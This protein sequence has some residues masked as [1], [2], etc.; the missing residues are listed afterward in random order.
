MTGDNGKHG[1]NKAQRQ[2]S[3][4]MT[5]RDQLSQ[6]TGRPAAPAPA[7]PPRGKHQ[8]P[9]KSKGQTGHGHGRPSVTDVKPRSNYRFVPL[10]NQVHQPA[11][12]AQVSHDLPFRDG[13]CGS[14]R[15]RIDAHTP[16]F[17]GAGRAQAAKGNNELTPFRTAD[18]K[19]G[20]P[21]SSLRGML[22]NV[23]GIATFG[24]MGYIDD[25]RLGVRD[26]QNRNLYLEKMNNIQT[27]WMHYCGKD[28]QW[29]IRPVTAHRVKH[30]DLAGLPAFRKLKLCEKQTGI[31]RLKA[32][33]REN[34]RTHFDL[35]GKNGDPTKIIAKPDPKGSRAGY[36]V[37]TGQPGG[38]KKREFL[39]ELPNGDR[40]IPVDAAVYR[41]FLAIRTE[42]S[43]QEWED[44]RQFW[45]ELG[46]PVFYQ[47]TGGRVTSFGLAQ[48][49]KLPYRKT[50][51]EALA[52]TSQDHLDPSVRDFAELMFGYVQDTAALKG[53]VSFGDARLLGD[54]QLDEPV[55]AVL[56]QPRPS[57]YPYY[58]RQDK[59][60]GDKVT[61]YRTLMYDGVQLRGWKRYP[62]RPTASAPPA[63]EKTQGKVAS[64]FRPLRAGSRFE[65]TLRFHNLRPEE[66]GA[67]LWA[68]DF[69]SSR[70]ENGVLRH[71]IGLGKPFGLGQVSLAA[72][73]LDIRPNNPSADAPDANTLVQC[74]T[75]Y[76][77]KACPAGWANSAQINALKAMASPK[78][79]EQH[80]D[81][82]KYLELD[83]FVGIKKNNR[84]LPDYS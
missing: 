84:F 79:G 11:W 48:M 62:V 32:V 67:L 77:E 47:Q 54:E 83:D 33:G 25:Q 58:I 71:A 43:R 2:G 49:Y 66:L 37:L 20:I 5:L 51:H 76:M 10:S 23:I 16:I 52:N 8:P 30:E 13:L 64:R 18:G 27:G 1:N 28:R 80:E 46:A 45:K 41:D 69:G 81:S 36:I 12:A 55:F 50:L 75:T 72:E 73:T 14:I 7:Q 35:H 17:I 29:V 61:E 19:R 38:N 39:F 70:D 78:I 44:A 57:F 15:V 42:E 34:L 53:R 59:T 74:F 4:P 31:K 60:Q 68:L 63:D 21:G 22:R 6:Q 65:C 24:K 40:S 3:K 9:Q 26:L 82:L 56:G